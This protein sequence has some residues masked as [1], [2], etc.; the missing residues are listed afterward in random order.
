ME[1]VETK[2]DKP[3]RDVLIAD[4]G[5]IGDEALTSAADVPPSSFSCCLPTL[6]FLPCARLADVLT[7]ASLGPL[8]PSAEKLVAI[9]QLPS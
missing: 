8:L 1:H 5:E 3:V 4:C 6:A 2:G 7:T 9:V